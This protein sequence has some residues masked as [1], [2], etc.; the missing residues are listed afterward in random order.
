MESY[1][2]QYQLDMNRRIDDCLQKELFGID[3]ICNLF[4]AAINE[5]QYVR[6]EIIFFDNTFYLNADN[7]LQP[8]NPPP[9]PFPLLEPEDQCI[10]TIHNL[11]K[12]TNQ[13]VAI[14][15]NRRISLVALSSLLKTYLKHHPEI[16]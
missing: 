9:H 6:H 16:E 15:P 8:S 10:V 12:I 2:V 14:C 4:E 5:K 1:I 11:K 3:C 13:L 7:V